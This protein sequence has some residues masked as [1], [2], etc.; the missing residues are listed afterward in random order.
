MLA[1]RF[2]KV[3]LGKISCGSFELIDFCKADGRSK[4]NYSHI[5]RDYIRR[6]PASRRLALDSA[7]ANC[8]D[9]ESA[10]D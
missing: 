4:M 8:M 3:N 5:L 2:F 6:L 7:H 1:S 10:L 9:S